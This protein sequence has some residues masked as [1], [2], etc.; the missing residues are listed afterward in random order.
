MAVWASPG[1][2]QTGLCPSTWYTSSTVSRAQSVTRQLS[3]QESK[4][5]DLVGSGRRMGGYTH[6]RG[7]HVGGLGRRAQVTGEGP[8]CLSCNTSSPPGLE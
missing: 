8:S 6:R 2:A 4:P 1:G 5:L 7:G 3:S